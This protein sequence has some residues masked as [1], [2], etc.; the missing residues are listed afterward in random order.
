[1]ST[2]ALARPA[3]TRPADS[4]RTPVRSRVRRS[5][6]RLTRRGRL[7]VVVLGIGLMFGIGVWL[8]AGSVATDDHGVVEVEVVTVAQGETLWDIAA[9]AADGG[10]VR[11][12]MER[13][14]DFNTL[15]SSMVHT[16]QELRIPLD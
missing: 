14:Q 12:M 9:D 4:R 1:M 16:G 11:S 10:D 13:I 6:V 7:A 3:R 5:P 15:D 2:I 8:A